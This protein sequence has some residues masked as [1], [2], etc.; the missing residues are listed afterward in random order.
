MPSSCLHQHSIHTV[1]RHTYRQNIQTQWKQKFEQRERAQMSAGARGGLKRAI[2]PLELEHRW[3]WNIWFGLWGPNP[4]PLQELHP[5]NNHRVTSPA[6]HHLN[7]TSSFPP[8]P[9]VPKN[10]L[11]DRCSLQKILPF[12]DFILYLCG[13]SSA[14]P[15]PPSLL[16]CLVVLSKNGALKVFWLR[17]QVNIFL[18]TFCWILFIMSS[19]FFW[20]SL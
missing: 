12:P 11:P 19:F 1:H 15:P 14:F 3:L 9:E 13:K 17:N 2:D 10:H 18:W 16:N 8:L 5:F 7:M 6:P 20:L 4:C